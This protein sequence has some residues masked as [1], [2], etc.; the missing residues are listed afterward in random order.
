[1]RAGARDAARHLGV[2]G[3]VA[4][5]DDGSVEGL[6]CGDSCAVARFCEWLELGP[7]L[8]RVKRVEIEPVPH[9]RVHG[10]KIH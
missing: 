6:A 8:A 7:V 5:R 4:N 2:T 3:W 1:F 9:T 10:F